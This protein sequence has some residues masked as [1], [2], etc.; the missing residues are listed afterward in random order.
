MALYQQAYV[1]G[2]SP[3]AETVEGEAWNVRCKEGYSWT[4][5]STVKFINCTG[6][7]WSD[8]PIICG[9]LL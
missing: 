5:D 7:G 9:S 2:D 3:P 6:K 4:D 8:F 1:D